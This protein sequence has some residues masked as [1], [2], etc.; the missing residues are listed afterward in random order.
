M[1]L[2]RV[3]AQSSLPYCFTLVYRLLKT[4]WGNGFLKTVIKNTLVVWDEMEN[5]LIIFW[6]LHRCKVHKVNPVSMWL[7]ASVKGFCSLWELRIH[8]MTSREYRISAASEIPLKELLC[9]LKFHYYFWFH[10]ALHT[11]LSSKRGTKILKNIY[12]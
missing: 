5:D 9:L 11:F 2:P 10:F 6:V 4:C 1:V 7:S 12:M 8:R 3:E